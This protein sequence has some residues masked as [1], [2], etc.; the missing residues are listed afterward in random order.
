MTIE[1][2]YPTAPFSPNARLRFDV[3]RRILNR[4]GSSGSFLE[5]GCGQG[6]LA[7]VLTRHFEYV[8]Y[9]PDPVSFQTAFHRLGSLKSGRVVNDVLPAEVNRSFDFVG[10]FEVL[11]H[12]EDDLIALKEWVRWLRTG[13]HAIVSVPAH[14][15]RFGPADI[16]VGHFRR[17][18]RASIHALLRDAGLVDVEVVAYGFPLGYLLEW[19][20][21]RIASRNTAGDTEMKERSAESGRFLQPRGTV[22][23]LIWAGTW[24]FVVLQ[25]PFAA[26]DLG[27]GWIA[28][29]R[30]S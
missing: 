21:N 23:P 2:L 22:S 7:S 16:R 27:T 19:A 3:I 20:R 1:S 13:G 17:Y 11:E 9:E 24:P 8:G 4:V 29:G 14:P 30:R 12:L 6:A 26:S 25:R 10:A 15:D 5:I 18:T 28:H